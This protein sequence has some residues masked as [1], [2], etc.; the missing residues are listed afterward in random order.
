MPFD[1]TQPVV[2]LSAWPCGK[3]WDCI[4]ADSHQVEQ[5]GEIQRVGDKF[6][7]LALPDFSCVAICDTLRSAADHLSMIEYMPGQHY[8][9]MPRID[10][11]HAK[12][13]PCYKRD[14]AFGMTRETRPALARR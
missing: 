6:W 4:V 1:F 2:S 7:A 13:L 12:P 3:R 8:L 5:V 10:V 9:P 14:S 11:S